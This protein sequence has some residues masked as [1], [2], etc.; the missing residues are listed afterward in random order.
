M[1]FQ[2]KIEVLMVKKNFAKIDKSLK[3]SSLALSLLIFFT[4]NS[5][6]QKYLFSRKKRLLKMHSILKCH[7]EI[8]QIIKTRL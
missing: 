3:F 5:S 7:K 2:K 8:V 6:T 1:N 4:L